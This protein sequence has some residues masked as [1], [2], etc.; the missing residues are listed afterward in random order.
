[1]TKY[2]FPALYISNMSNLPKNSDEK[3]R[4]W[5][6]DSDDSNDIEDGRCTASSGFRPPHECRAP[7]RPRHQNTESTLPPKKLCF[8][9]SKK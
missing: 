5:D 8:E 4:T 3:K 7:T 9:T 2:Y 6:E 1:M